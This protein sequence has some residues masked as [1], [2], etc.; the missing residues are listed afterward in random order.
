[1]L[2]RL[3]AYDLIEKIVGHLLFLIVVDWQHLLV[4]LIL[5]VFKHLFVLELPTQLIIILLVLMIPNLLQSSHNQRILLQLHPI[6]NKL[7]L[8]SLLLYEQ[9]VVFLLPL[10]VLLISLLILALSKDHLV[11]HN[12]KTI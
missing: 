7:L 8:L 10:C 9:V 1:M 6:L 3:Y 5:L 2:W 12:I 11:R 4:F